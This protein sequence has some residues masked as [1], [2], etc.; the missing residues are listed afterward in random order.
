MSLEKMKLNLYEKVIHN[1]SLLLK[2]ETE[3]VE[4]VFSRISVIVTTLNIS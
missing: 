4:Y 1:L 3:N 2:E